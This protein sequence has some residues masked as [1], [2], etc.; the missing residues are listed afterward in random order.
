MLGKL[1]KHDKGYSLIV[2]NVEIAIYSNQRQE[3]PLY[4]LSKK[5]CEVIFNGYD[6]DEL[7]EDNFKGLRD[8]ISDSDI[9]E[10]YISLVKTTVTEILGD[11]KFSEEDMRKAYGIGFSQHGLKS[12]YSHIQSLQQT[13]W[14]VEIVTEP[15]NLDEIREQGKGFLNSNTNKPKL[16]ENGCIVLRKL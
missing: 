15:M 2:D 8:C 11:K 9:A 5:N 14:D 10:F 3:R 1:L 12:F 6:L 7:V 13:E 16:D 4:S